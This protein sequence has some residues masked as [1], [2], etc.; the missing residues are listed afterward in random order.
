[1]KEKTDQRYRRE[2]PEIL[3]HKYSQM[4]FDEGAMQN[5]RAKKIFSTN[6]AGTTGYPHERKR[7]GEG[8]GKGKRKKKD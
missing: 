2:S 4:I 8:K 6:G 1:M 3:P 5:N 7:E